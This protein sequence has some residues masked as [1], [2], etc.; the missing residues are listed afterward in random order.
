MKRVSSIARH[1]CTN[2]VAAQEDEPKVVLVTGCTSGL[3]YALATEF[4]RLGHTVVGC[5][6]RTDRIESMQNEFG[7]PHYFD[8]V[9]SSDLDAVVAFAERVR[10]QGLS[11]D[12]LINNAGV[13][14]GASL[15]WDIEPFKFDQVV[16]V[17]I[18]GVFYMSK[19]FIPG[20]IG[21]HLASGNQK[22][23]I[24]IS[25][26]LGHSTSPIL[27]AYNTSKWAVESMS[28]SFAQGFQ[29]LQLD[30]ICVPLAPG[31][32]HTEMNTKEGIPTA[33]EWAPI[34]AQ[35]ILDI[36]LSEN[37]SSL[38]VPGFYSEP[39]QSTWVIPPGMKIPSKFVMPQ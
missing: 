18:K 16:D 36:P 4:A 21:H 23:V 8:S 35:F 9:D 25:S 26:G 11:V 30:C 34:A 28:K 2:T 20:M 12:V 5:A 7:S 13:S 31:V 14:A 32:I 19:T 17:N 29:A 37:G 3:G 39:Y 27:M 24:N 22:K 38:C 6:R 10:N 15:P 33:K 1:V